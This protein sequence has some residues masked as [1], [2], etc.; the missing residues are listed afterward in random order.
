MKILVLLLVFAT[1]CAN[2]QIF[3]WVKYL[4]G[5][6]GGH[7]YMSAPHGKV[8]AI[9]G[10]GNV[11]LTANNGYL[12]KYTPQ[13]ALIWSK[14]IGGNGYALTIDQLG[15]IYIVGGFYDT[16]DADPGPQ[17]DTLAGIA[18]DVFV[19]KLDANANFV[20]ARS[21]GGI[22]ADYATD[23]AVDLQSN[24]YIVGS[25]SDST[26]FDP[27]SGIEFAD[28]GGAY[29]TKLDSAGDYLWT[30]YETFTGSGYLDFNNSVAVDDSF[31]IYVSSVNAVNTMPVGYVS[32][33]DSTGIMSW[34]KQYLNSIGENIYD[35]EISDSGYLFAVGLMDFIPGQTPGVFFIQK[36]N[37]SG[38]EIWMS[39]FGR[40]EI[41]WQANLTIDKDGN[42]YAIG[43]GTFG[44][45]NYFYPGAPMF[46]TY[47]K[48]TMF[49]IKID[50]AGVPLWGG[51][52]GIVNANY[53]TSGYG[54]E[55]DDNCGV[56]LAGYVKGTVNIGLYY[57]IG[58]ALLTGDGLFLEKFKCTS[59]EGSMMLLSNS[60]TTLHPNPTT[61][62]F[63]LK[64]ATT[65]ADKSAS[66]EIRD[67]L[68]KLVYRTIEQ[69]NNGLKTEINLDENIAPGVYFLRLKTEGGEENIRFVKE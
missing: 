55:V 29:L 39:K 42:S 49:V 58:S 65:S 19:T 33:F 53:Q 25:F 61:G 54:I 26:D 59:L 4:G 52:H 30:Y 17:F 36:M 66:I 7:G 62:S 12:K 5:I 31:N 67:V 56:Y 34:R 48:P 60:I 16:M 20:W 63:T 32:R 47:G 3:Q 69:I 15:Y 9:D 8:T 24:V 6:P 68:G 11:Y 10:N 57:T 37:L 27:G 51:F 41:D 21:F 1:T 64:A 13:G 22:H 50:P 18:G 45:N 40:S 2:A 23:V 38:N 43:S 14:N 44:V 35:L 46:T 28:T